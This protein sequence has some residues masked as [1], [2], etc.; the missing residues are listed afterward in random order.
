MTIGY[1]IIPKLECIEDIQNLPCIYNK[2]MHDF[3]HHTS[4][5]LA[6]E[7]IKTDLNSFEF[8]FW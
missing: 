2:N 3:S 4:I 7:S 1:V 6:A 5:I 8:N